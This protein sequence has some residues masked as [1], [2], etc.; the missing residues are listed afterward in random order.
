MINMHDIKKGAAVI[1]DGQP[2]F[3][4]DFKRAG[5]GQRRPVLHV[6]LRHVV[7]G[8]LSEKTL[9]EKDVLEEPNVERSVVTFSYR[10]GT[11]LVFMDQRTYEQVELPAELIGENADLLGQDVEVRLMVLD[12]VPVGIELPP[13]VTLEVVETPDPQRGA[14]SSR[15]SSVGKPAK[16]SNGIEVEVPLFIKKGERIRIDTAT[17]QYQGKDN[18]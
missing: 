3:V 6:K 15:T 5:T 13:S 10:S 4:V 9:A 2:F 12:G 18:E 7:T 1:V 14:P 16:L 11:R 8:A 17:R